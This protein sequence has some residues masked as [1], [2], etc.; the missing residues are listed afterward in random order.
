[1]PILSAK[2]QVTLPK[3]LCDKLHILPRDHLEFLAHDSCMTIIKK[4]PEAS[5]GI[6]CHLAT[7]KRVADDESLAGALLEGCQSKH[8]AM[9]Q[10]CKVGNVC[11]VLTLLNIGFGRRKVIYERD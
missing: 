5:K 6:F 2:R 8:C 7:K 10:I 3:E 1:M 4:Q 9:M 11:N